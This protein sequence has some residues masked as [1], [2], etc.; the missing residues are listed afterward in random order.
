FVGLQSDQ[1]WTAEGLR[2]V[3]VLTRAIED[4]PVVQQVISPTNAT[5]AIGTP[6][7]MLIRD[8]A[9]DLP[10][11]DEA[12]VAHRDFLLSQESLRGTVVSVDGEV[13]AIMVFLAA[14]LETT[15]S[16]AA[17]QIAEAVE[18]SKGSLTVYPTGRPLMNYYGSQKI[19]KE[20]GMLASAAIL[21]MTVLLG[22]LFLNLRGV[23]LPVGV[24]IGSVLWTMGGMGWIQLPMTHSTEALPILLIAIGVADGVHIVQAYMGRAREAPDRIAAVRW[25][26]DDLRSPVIMTSITSAV[27]FLAL[28]TSGI[29]SI[30]ILGLLTAFGILVALL[31][32][33]TLL[34]ATLALLPIPKRA[35]HDTIRTEGY[36]L[37]RVMVW[38]GDLLV[39]RRGV[40]AGGILALVAL[41][42]FGS[43]RV[44]VETSL[45]ANFPEEDPIY[46]S[47]MFVNEHFAGVT[48]VQVVFEGGAPN[49]VKDPKFL[50]EVEAFEE[51]V[52]T[53][54]GV[55][56]SVSVVPFLTSMSMVLHG[57]DPSW[58]RLPDDIEVEHGF[59]Y[60]I[61]AE[62]NEIEIP[63][64]RE[65]SGRQVIDG[66]FSLFEMNGRA[67][68]L[69][70]MVTG[71][72][73]SAKVTVFLKSD[74]K[75]DLDRVV[76]DVRSYM[77]EHLE[78]TEVEMTGMA[79]LMLAI[80]DLITYGQGA[81]ILV[82]L[83]LVFLITSY[84][85]RS[86]TLGL[87]NVVPL[88]AALF[89][90]FGVMGLFGLDL[91][92]MTMGVASMAI[93]VGV[94]FA[95]HFI[96]R[97]RVSFAEAGNPRDALRLTFEEAG[98]TL[99]LA[100]FKGVMTM[101]LLIS[102]IM[103]FS[104]VGALTILP[105]LFLWVRPKAVERASKGVA[106]A[107]LALL[108]LGVAS[109]AVA[110]AEPGDGRVYM[111]EVL[112]RNAFEDMVGRITLT[113]T[114]P[115]GG[116][117]RQRRG[118]DRPH[119][120]HGGARGHA[121][122]RVPGPG[123]QQRRRRP[124]HL[125][126]RHGSGESHRGLRP[127]RLLHVIGLLLRGHRE[128][129]PGGLGV[130]TRGDHRSGW[131]R[132]P[133]GG[134][135]PGGRLRPQGHWLHQGRLRHRPGAEDL[136]GDRLLRQAGREVQAS[137][138]EQDSGPERRSL[139]HRHDH[140]RPRQRPHFTDEDGGPRGR[141]GRRF[142]VVHQPRPAEGLLSAP[143][144][145]SCSPC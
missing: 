84:M 42:I 99:L 131:P 3:D 118:G 37:Q 93:G 114:A 49:A 17:G 25:T 122:E 139:R 111:E 39:R 144:A 27:G 24:V 107:G 81:S 136:P 35:K 13:A 31:F 23:L 38:W 26:M 36:R 119:P 52:A 29:R 18:A 67:K 58:D 89:F 143:C 63:V 41:A 130:D 76:T 8:A 75:K 121:G 104:A 21:L 134:G 70:N 92:L 11:T 101:G 30:M 96:H 66:Y 129:G 72:Y 59:D 133:V 97:Y 10:A 132:L 68:D 43:T 51:H 19:G 109:P 120:P 98:L 116:L 60:D 102:L 128:P 137:P 65:V 5:V 16:K 113:L 117:P 85:F 78:D 124:L 140:D 64:T 33:L 14:K 12:A 1:L 127:R 6:E 34:P 115:N 91:N 108:V 9:E 7:G 53:V 69:S 71:D 47:S 46:Q 145:G 103:A 28:N 20:T 83:V 54:E 2:E 125:C 87:F 90:N 4:V 57:G 45:L 110:Q 79:I 88:S 112:D 142:T 32:S 22:L 80:N 94:D 123:P 126:P 44:G 73:S 106:A 50:R 100:S 74:R 77:D 135:D 40:A 56:G 105:I 55:G 141:P 82:S 61:D 15:E 138:G 86:P 95:I 62:G 48:N